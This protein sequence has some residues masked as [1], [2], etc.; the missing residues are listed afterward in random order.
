MMPTRIK[1]QVNLNPLFYLV[2]E[3]KYKY[4]DLICLVGINQ[5]H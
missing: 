5:S 1:D 3:L 2:L 4:S